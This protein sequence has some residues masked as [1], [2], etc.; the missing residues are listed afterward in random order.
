[1]RT[2]DGEGDVSVPR[3]W[4]LRG[5]GAKRDTVRSMAGQ[6]ALGIRGMSLERI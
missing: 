5:K 1:M 6:P 3:E 2:R 4:A